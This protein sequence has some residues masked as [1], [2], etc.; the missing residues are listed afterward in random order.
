[1]KRLKI[2]NMQTIAE[3]RDT[4]Y[5]KTRI[6]AACETAPTECFIQHISELVNKTTV[7]FNTITTYLR[8]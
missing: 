8:N 2:L 4:F 1:M 3:C 7:S 5:K 6:V